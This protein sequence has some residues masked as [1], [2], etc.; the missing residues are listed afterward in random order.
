MTSGEL[1]AES[2]SNEK[3]SA[4]IL[5]RIRAGDT[6]ATQEFSSRFW[7]GIEFLLRRKLGKSDVSGEV[8]AVIDAAIRAIQST[9]PA[10]AV[11][12]PRLIVSTIHLQ[13]G[14]PPCDVGSN[15]TDAVAERKAKSVIAEMSPE[16]QNVLQRYYVRGDS[17]EAIQ[18]RLHLSSQA[19]KDTLW[20][21]RSRFLRKGQDAGSR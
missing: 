15:R 8:A 6:F 20:K 18:S 9:A 5:R 3:G 17:L 16:E 7:A 19:I 14:S 12:L 13:F 4:E 10:E 2:S 11:D 21:A 1:G